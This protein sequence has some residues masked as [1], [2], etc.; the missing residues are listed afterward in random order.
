MRADLRQIR[1]KFD[2]FNELYFRGELPS[3]RIVMNDSGR[4]LGMFVHP[5]R[6]SLLHPSDPRDCVLKISR[7]FDLPEAEIED[8]LIHEMIHYYI[9]Y[10]RMRDTSA[11]GEIFRRLMAEINS[12]YGRN[13]TVSRR[14]GDDTSLIDLRIKHHYIC[15]TEFSD[16]R[17]LLTVCARSRIFDIDRGVSA[18]ADAQGHSWYWSRDPWF[19]RYPASRTLKFYKADPA[20]LAV[21]LA[22]AV[23]CECAGSVFRPVRPVRD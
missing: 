12:R 6:R 20:Q 14:C 22:D 19:N 9:W 8:T 7:R 18:L 4:A 15:V 21:H 11:H 16:G 2:E 10:K 5:R 1:E 17:Q 23:A 3:V 13:I